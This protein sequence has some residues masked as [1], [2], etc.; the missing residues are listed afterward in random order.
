MLCVAGGAAARWVGGV[1]DS[2]AG[3]GGSV[4]Q[5]WQGIANPRALFPGQSRLT[6]LLVGQ[7]Y[8]RDRR[9]IAYTKQSRSDTIMLL[10]LDLEARKLQAVSVPRDTL[11]RA[12][13]G[14]SGKINGTFSRGG[15][16]LLRATLEERFNIVVDEYVVIKP[17]AMRNIVDSVGGVEVESIDEMHYDDNWGG[18]HVHLP[19]GRF[20][21]NG[22]E[23][24]GFVRFREVNRYE[25]TERGRMVPIRGVRGSLEEGD[26]RRAARQQ[27]LVASLISSA[28][29]PRNLLRADRIIAT[30][31]NQIDT[32]LSRTQCLALA[33]IMR[34]V[35][36]QGLKSD[37]VPGTDDMRGGAY[38]YVLD[39][40]RAQ[41][42]VDWLIKGDAAA[43]RKLVRVSVKNGTDTAGRARDT[44]AL[45]ERIGYTAYSAG[46]APTAPATIVE[47]RKADYRDAAEEIRKFIG[48]TSIAKAED[49]GQP[50]DPEVQIVIGQDLVKPAGA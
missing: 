33:T 38:Y 13:D 31:F 6:L 14:R 9:G 25:I 40:E 41:A 16:D 20:H 39:D 37:T 18:L 30:G 24:E 49:P 21:V 19:K 23:A 1:V 15:I 8:N 5:V 3:E 45:L 42:T 32:S 27:Q 4:A 2:F 47:Y 26:I 44:A 12:P 43:M 17:D 50:W 28:N 11:V 48:A 35:S 46:N 7:D 22:E 34:G 36:G 10:S 29:S